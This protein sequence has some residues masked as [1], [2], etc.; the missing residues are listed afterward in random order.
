MIEEEQE[1]E[2]EDFAFNLDNL[3]LDFHNQND[4]DGDN[5]LPD[6]QRRLDEVSLSSAD[7]QTPYVLLAVRVE[8]HAPSCGLS[9]LT[10]TLSL[11]STNITKSF[12]LSPLVQLYSS[13]Q[14]VSVFNVAEYY[15]P[16]QLLICVYQE[17]LFSRRL[18][19][20]GSVSLQECVRLQARSGPKTESAY[21][22]VTKSVYLDKSKCSVMDSFSLHMRF[23]ELKHCILSD[24]IL[25]KDLVCMTEFQLAAS[26][27]P[28]KLLREMLITLSR[29]GFVR[30]A[31][32]ARHRHRSN[33]LDCA[34]LASNSG[35]ARELLERCGS[36]C[37][38][39]TLPHK[40]CA[41]HAA[42]QGGS[43][44]SLR[45]VLRFIKRYGTRSIIGWDG[46]YCDY[47]EWYDEDGYTP[48]QRESAYITPH[49]HQLCDICVCI[50]ASM[51]G[52]L[53]IVRLLIRMGVR[54]EN[55]NHISHRTALMLAVDGGH[56]AVAELLLSERERF[57]GEIGLA[58]PDNQGKTTFIY[59]SHV[60]HLYMQCHRGCYVVPTRRM[61][62]AKP[63][64]S[65][66]WRRETRIW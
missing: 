49:L 21:W 10:A 44:E 17:T 46:N 33:A 42:V 28:P 3:H 20:S 29:F 8:P 45:C 37:F 52:K 5:A 43:L 34:L 11:A 58:S 54:V 6:M 48:L 9:R 24:Y 15:G 64:S 13:I 47:L 16:T 12:S 40:S 22:G 61:C 14:G 30:E 36:L 25:S 27:G 65:W 38:Q 39:N 57:L 53:E 2:F 55:V 50:V 4:L 7:R 63:P 19:F 56:R 1:E 59:I 60:S 23:I 41:L 32:A 66:Q 62:R 35:N 31:L 18:V 51:T 26:Y